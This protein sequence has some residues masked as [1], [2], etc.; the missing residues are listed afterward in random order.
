MYYRVDD[1][2]LGIDE[3]RR[4]IVEFDLETQKIRAL[5]QQSNLT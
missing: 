1:L 2:G 3:Y 4:Y 5:Y